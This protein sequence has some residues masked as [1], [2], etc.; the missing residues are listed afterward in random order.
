MAREHPLLQ[1]RLGVVESAAIAA[2]ESRRLSP[3]DRLLRVELE[4]CHARLSEA[5][6]DADADPGRAVELFEAMTTDGSLERWEDE[7]RAERARSR[8]PDASLGAG[9]AVRG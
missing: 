6:W 4:E 7:E 9:D 5:L 8:D 1:T 2:A 3:L